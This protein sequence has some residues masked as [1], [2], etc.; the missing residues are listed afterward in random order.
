M[1]NKKS[2]KEVK[3]PENRKISEK[4]LKG[5]RVIIAKYANLAPG[6]IADMMYGYRR[7]T[8]NVA[9]AIIRLMKEREELNRSLDEIINQ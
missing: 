2:S 1:K 6:T 7:I 3:F 9:R 4:L 5:D 8:D